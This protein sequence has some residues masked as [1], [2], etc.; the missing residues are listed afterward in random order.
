M[1]EKVGILHPG[2]MGISVAVSAQNGGNAV[3]WAS[4]G[5][6]PQTQGR[7]QKHSLIDVYSL[8]KLCETCSLIISVCPPHVAEE[9]AE[10]VLAHSFQGLYVDAN[11]IA[12][13]RAIRIGEAMRA[14]GVAFVDGGIIGGPAWQ[15]NTT[16]LYLSGGEAERVASCFPAGP[17]HTQV[18]GERIGQASALKM[19]YAA[20]TK[21]TTALLCAI[22]GTAE[23]LGV[24]EE[25]EQQWA[26]EGSD[27]AGQA[28]QRMTKV[29]AKAWRFAG[30]MEE[31]AA[32]FEEAGMPGGFH[33]ASADIYRRLAHFK[34]PAVTPSLAA[35][36]AA[37]LHEVRP[38]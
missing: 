32:T 38:S 24:R 30:E 5:R 10:Q 15:A 7:V 2:E 36:L 34:D 22:L 17:L 19:C 25:L 6:S 26:R 28:R 4:Q 14:G 35:V 9:V 27:F 18:L 33:E 8:A 1:I 20:Y 37:L 23:G 13:Q 29:T 31:I 3:F 21:G 12:P 16:W 11:A